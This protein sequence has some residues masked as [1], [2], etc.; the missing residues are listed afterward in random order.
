MSYLSYVSRQHID[1]RNVLVIKCLFCMYNIN[2]NCSSIREE[3]V[4]LSKHSGL[5]AQ[6]PVILCDFNHT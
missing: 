1:L 3:F 5:H 2:R 6:H 4:L